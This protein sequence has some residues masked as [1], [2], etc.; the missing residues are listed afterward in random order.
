MKW[1]IGNMGAGEV[2]GYVIAGLIIA[3]VLLWAGDRLFTPVVAA[4]C[5]AGASQLV[6]EHLQMPK[7]RSFQVLMA[8]FLG[9]YIIAGGQ[10]F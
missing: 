9:T 1:L 5:F 7:G 10:T 3:L 2:A 4:S 8:V 6:C